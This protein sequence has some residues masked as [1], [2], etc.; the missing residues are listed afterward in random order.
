MPAGVSLTRN[1]PQAFLQSG[2]ENCI[3]MRR[4]ARQTLMFPGVS[5]PQFARSAE[6]SPCENEHEIEP[7]RVRDPRLVRGLSRQELEAGP[8]AHRSA[9]EVCPAGDGFR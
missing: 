6:A 8:R 9:G 4:I 5:P 7:E 2:P 1:A 3:E